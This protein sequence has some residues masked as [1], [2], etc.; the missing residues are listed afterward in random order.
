MDSAVRLSY[1]ALL[2]IME[3]HRFG[4]G[5]GGYRIIWPFQAGDPAPLRAAAQ[6]GHRAG[7]QHVR[8]LSGESLSGFGFF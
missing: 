4:L 1:Q 6:H 8:A 3:L 7:Q 5:P 2:G